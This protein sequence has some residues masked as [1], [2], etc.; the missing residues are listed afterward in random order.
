M[1]SKPARFPKF[2]E[3]RPTPAGC[4][5]NILHLPVIFNYSI[6]KTA[7]RKTV[8]RK[9]F[10]VRVIDGGLLS[11]FWGDKMIVGVASGG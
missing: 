6:I 7:K 10:S 1:P 4:C 8:N 2:E 11:V 3:F 9:K 5:L